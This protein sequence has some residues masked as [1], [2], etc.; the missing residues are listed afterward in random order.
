MGS[1]EERSGTTT[2]KKT[3]SCLMIQ[4]KSN[5]KITEG[6]LVLA[7]LRSNKYANKIRMHSVMIMDVVILAI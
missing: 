2:L 6:I 1:N 5:N 3:V 7:E 4:P